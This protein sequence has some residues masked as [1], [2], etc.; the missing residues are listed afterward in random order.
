MLSFWD[1]EFLAF[2]VPLVA[3]IRGAK[4]QL[5]AMGSLILQRLIFAG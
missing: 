4:L 3:I 5:P 1:L 2:G